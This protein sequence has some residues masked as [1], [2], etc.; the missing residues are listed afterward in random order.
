MEDQTGNDA[1]PEGT[2]KDS[3]TGVTPTVVDTAALIAAIKPSLM[4]VITSSVR[5]M[6]QADKD[7]QR[8]QAYNKPKENWDPNSDAISVH[9]GSSLTSSPSK[10]SAPNFPSDDM[11]SRSSHSHE[12]EEEEEEPARK[13]IRV[14]SDLH[15][16]PHTGVNRE[17]HGI[18]GVNRR[19]NTVGATHNDHHLD[20]VEETLRACE[21]NTEFVEEY[22]PSID[23]KLASAVI[24]HFKRGADH[25]ANRSKLFIKHKL[26]ANLAELNVPKVNPGVLNLPDVK[27]YHQRNETKL[28]DC[29]Q[30]VTRATMA[31]AKVADVV[32][33]YEKMSKVVTPAE[34][35]SPCL[36]AIALLG[37]AS[38]E[39][40]NRRKY[41]LKY[42]VDNKMK[43]LC[44]PDKPT[45]QWLLGDD[46][47]KEISE[48]KLMSQLRKSTPKKPT[49]TT[50][51]SAGRGG[52]SGY[53]SHSSSSK[54]KSGSSNK[55]SFLDKGK[56]SKKGK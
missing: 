13:K 26:A 38:R 30:T 37:H 3:N 55:P 42:C 8:T 50:E 27:Q 46:I 22:N 18:A 1:V 7:S 39:L 29:Q 15:A 45:T 47:G 12:T 14:H 44:S 28:F 9:P 10:D 19:Q 49:N 32:F 36:E 53:S 35:V 21:E 33:Q 6:V 56:K 48:A 43:E 16:S 52:Y 31:V 5:E 24:K 54:P 23:D 40:S 11:I 51:K 2:K 4:D 25:S 20:M 41:N 34:V 17:E